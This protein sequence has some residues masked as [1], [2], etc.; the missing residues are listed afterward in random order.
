MVQ[1]LELIG[2]REYAFDTLSLFQVV[3]LNLSFIYLFL[4]C[5]SMPGFQ[6]LFSNF[7]GLEFLQFVIRPAHPV[8]PLL[9]PLALTSYLFLSC[10]LNPGFGE[11]SVKDAGRYIHEK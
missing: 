6:F 11:A 7:K 4:Y 8:F 10:G 2:V 1:L 9:L 3:F 5:C